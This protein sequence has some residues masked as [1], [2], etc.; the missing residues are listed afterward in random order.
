MTKKKIVEEI[1]KE[2]V[3]DIN[4][5]VYTIRQLRCIQDGSEIKI[6]EIKKAIENQEVD[7]LWIFSISNKLYKEIISYLK[8]NEIKHIVYGRS[9]ITIYYI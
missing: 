7:E 1:A 9:R 2:P 3:N 8:E 4:T 6:K 5:N